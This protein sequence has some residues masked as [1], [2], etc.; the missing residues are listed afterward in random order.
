MDNADTVLANEAVLKRRYRG[1]L[2]ARVAQ[3]LKR[4]LGSDDEV[5]C[6]HALPE[7]Q[8][9]YKLGT[10]RLFCEREEAML[11]LGYADIVVTRNGQVQTI[12]EVEESSFSPRAIMGDIDAYTRAEQ[13]SS[14]YF[15]PLTIPPTVARVVLCAKQTRN[16]G[17]KLALYDEHAKRIAGQ[18]GAADPAYVGGFDYDR[19]GVHQPCSPDEETKAK[20]LANR[21]RG[22]ADLH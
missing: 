12:I 18:P 3:I 21:I 19:A 9:S 15:K 1:P 5:Y 7:G 20:E 16:A 4:G 11:Y 13:V 6:G 2:T 8:E 22:V 17:Q 10:L 14:K